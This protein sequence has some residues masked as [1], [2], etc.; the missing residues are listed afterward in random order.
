MK[1]KLLALDLDDTLLNDEFI[2]SA[3]N[4]E[5]IQKVAKKGILPVIA[6]GRMF[7]SALPYARQLGVDLPL[8]TY[9]GALIKNAGNEEILRHCTIPYE[10]AAGIIRFGEKNKLH[11]N[12]YLDDRLFIEEES[13]ESHY[14]QSI[15]SIP[16]NPVGDLSVF[17]FNRQQEP[18]K[19]TF[20]NKEGYL[21]EIESLLRSIYPE[22][23]I[24]QSRPYFLEI[25]HRDATKGQALN[26]LAKKENILP[27][28]IIAIGDSY[29]D[30]DMLEFAGLGV[31]V[32][33][34]PEEV[35]KAADVITGLNTEDGVAAFL[36]E[37][38]L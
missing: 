11:L 30:I 18:T 1:Y 15:A 27:E 9:H 2:I 17:L 38:F 32:G 34:A 37:Y 10:M 19:I 36:E 29:N 16:V 20:I 14:Y 23:S 33:N 7:C 26:F 8:I 31:A 28:Q 25:T 35:K 22:L 12:L 13:T 6:T 4:I 3:R 21:S 24:L 5:A